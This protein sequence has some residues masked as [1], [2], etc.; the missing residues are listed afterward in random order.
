MRIGG[1]FPTFD[2][3][4]LIVSKVLT[5][6][7]VALRHCQSQKCDGRGIGGSTHSCGYYDERTTMSGFDLAWLVADMNAVDHDVTMAQSTING[8]GGDCLGLGGGGY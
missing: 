3:G 2:E 6:V 8:N 7:I 4:G 5:V 1:V